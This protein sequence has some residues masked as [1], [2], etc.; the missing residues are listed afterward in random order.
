MNNLLNNIDNNI[1]N[2]N[3]SVKYKK[4]II[5]NSEKSAV[6]SKWKEPGAALYDQLLNTF[7][8]VDDVPADTK[9]L[10][11]AIKNGTYKQWPDFIKE[12]YLIA[13]VDNIN[14]S[15]YGITPYSRSGCKYPHHVI[16]DGKLVLSIEG[17]KHAYE[18]AWKHNELTPSINRHLNRHFK[19]LG[20]RPWFHHGQMVYLKEN[21]MNM[22]IE[23]NF[24]SIEKLI[25][26]QSGIDLYCPTTLFNESVDDKTKN[27]IKPLTKNDVINSY[28]VNWLF[29]SYEFSDDD[30]EKFNFDIIVND[31]SI[32][33]YV[34]GY[35]I[36]D[37]LEGIIKIKYRKDKDYYAI[38]M[39]FVNK[40]NESKGIGQSLM[41]YAID[42]Y[43]NKEMRLNVFDFNDRAIHIYKKFGFEIKSTE[44]AQAESDGDSNKLVGKKFYKMVRKSN[45]YDEEIE[46]SI[47]WIES[48]VN[49]EEFREYAEGQSA[50]LSGLQ[51]LEYT[52]YMDFRPSKTCIDEECD[53]MYNRN[54]DD[55][56][57][58]ES[59]LM[60]EEENKEENNV[61]NKKDNFVPI[62]GIVKSYSSESVRNDGTIKSAGELASVK[63]DKIIHKLTRGDNYSHALVSFDDSLT[64]MYS[65]EDEGFVI[66]NIM[67]KESWMGTKSIYICVMFVNKDDR[68]RMKSYIMDLK[69]HQHQTKYASAN[70][71]KAYIGTPKKIDK[72]FVCSSFTGYIMSC[73]NPKNLHRDFSRLRPEDITILPRAFYVMNVKDREEF[74]E[75]RSEIKS[76][77]KSI[78]KEYHDEID[79][80]NNHLPKILLKNRCDEL[81]TLDRIFDWIIDHME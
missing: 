68:D 23:E 77:V 71:L 7:H 62:F 50:G 40:N 30:P 13:P 61:N 27:V 73:A 2:I 11:K 81:K 74:K 66:D 44:I 3:E 79:D 41:K 43:G 18:I 21:A 39:L 32:G 6:K 53:N 31:E 19:E 16:R 67:E 20:I 34:Y 29:K 33:N 38:S 72:R 47:R 58:M 28:F 78:Y 26:E 70:L 56:D 52:T 46:N 5:D 9:E 12:T 69:K 1:S 36:D 57:W 63:F 48:F 65:Y 45:K 54:D 4:L 15:P 10:N 60:E 17:L 35:F 8:C 64:K 42:K 76:K 59:Y 14:N 24:R 25:Y 49:N 51:L 37:K 75:K 80:Y 22:K 55:L